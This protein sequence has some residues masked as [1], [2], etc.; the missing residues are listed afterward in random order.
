MHAKRQQCSQ[1]DMMRST[2]Q[3]LH[4]LDVSQINTQFSS[5]GE[6]ENCSAR[7]RNIKVFGDLHDEIPSSP[8]FFHFSG[9]VVVEV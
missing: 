4:V 2:D 8:F 6:R 5:H 1:T 3:G 9:T 7:F